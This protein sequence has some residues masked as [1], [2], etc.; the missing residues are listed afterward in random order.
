MTRPSRATRLEEAF[1]TLP[2][3]AILR[4]LKPEEAADVA[5]ALHEAGFRFIEVPLNSPEP[6]ESIRIIRELLPDDTLVGAGTVT[7]SAEV[8]RLVAL[9]ADL[10]VM[11]HADTM[12]IRAA[13]DAGLICTPGVATPTE[14]FAALAAGAAALKIFPAEMVG[15]PVIKAIR[16][17][18]PPGTRLLPVGGITPTN[19]DPFL[20]AGVAGF[21][22]GSSVYKPGMDVQEIAANARAFVEA[23]SSRKRP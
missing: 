20:A 17:V 22:L 8:E 14:A 19:M 5:T 7:R 2:L 16:A 6:F 11:P 12:V 1:A 23:W 10:V 13:T 4:G 3:I 9:G 21:G 15:P 18:L